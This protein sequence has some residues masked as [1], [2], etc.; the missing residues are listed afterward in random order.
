MYIKLN[1]IPDIT[2]SVV[3]KQLPQKEMTKQ[4]QF[5]TTAGKNDTSSLSRAQIRHELSNGLRI[6]LIDTSLSLSAIMSENKTDNSPATVLQSL[7]N[8]TTNHACIVL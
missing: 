7:L 4:T 5:L 8:T 2:N 3:E 1:M 6:A